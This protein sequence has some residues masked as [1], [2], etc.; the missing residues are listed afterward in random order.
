MTTSRNR[1]EP[2][3]NLVSYGRHGPGR[4]DRLSPAQVEQIARTVRRVP[5]VMV[6][7][8]GG[9]TSPKAVAAHLRY[10]DRHGK[11]E[12]ELDN[13]ELLKGK[14]SEVDL[15]DEWDLEA[16]AAEA[17]SPYG[18]KPGRKAAKLAHNI[19]LSMPAGTPPDRLLAASRA[20][21]REQFALKHR[22]AMVLHTDQD[23][24]HVHLVLKAISEQG[25][26]LN[27]R[28]ATLRGWRHEFARHLRD[29]GVEAN[30]TER[31]VRGACR[32]RKSDGIYRATLRGA[33]THTRM[34][35]EAV[36]NELK[37]GH[38]GIEAG[39]A[40]LVQTRGDIERGWRQ[41]A[42]RLEAEGHQAL[43]IQ[44]NSFVGQLPSPK[45]ERDMIAH[46]LIERVR[47]R[48]AKERPEVTR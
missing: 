9:G 38:E 42:R 26:R 48:H 40:K 25:E 6:K 2:L 23:H 29:Q 8:S 5:E 46:A 24:P 20:F 15:A 11:L 47:D 33:S 3:L 21:A 16:D 4:V 10:I 22:Y 44:V 43:A 39:K 12:L 36:A 32:T 7:V 27:V 34:R 35:V 30:A 19:V 31:A 28:K 41:V 18:G 17:G 1:D 13:G 14:G 37:N 45:T